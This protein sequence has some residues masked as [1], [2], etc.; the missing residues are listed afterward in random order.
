MKRILQLSFLSIITFSFFSCEDTDQGCL[1]IFS[2]NYSFNA[3]NSC[4]SCCT[5]PSASFDFNLIH[6][7]TT[8]RLNR[9]TFLLPT[10]DSFSITKLEIVFSDF[11]FD[12]DT[13]SYIVRDTIEG[14][15]NVIKNDFVFYKTATSQSI[16]QTRFEDTIRMV[17]FRVGFDQ[18]ELETIK[19]FSEIDQSSNLDEALDTLYV[20]DPETYF[21]AR[22]NIRIK[23]SVRVITLEDPVENNLP[24]FDVAIPVK[25]GISWEMI[26][27]LDIEK[28]VARL[29]AEMTNEEIEL[30]FKTTLTSA[31]SFE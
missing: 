14:N 20:S 25:A 9:D 24:V 3:V 19:P 18:S 12:G 16:G 23:D 6:G 22:I 28:L 13:E 21:A 7:D 2:N 15:G 10:L 31:L 30:E 8:F 17:R 4:D 27:N 1:D 5:Y 26:C 11:Q 29:N